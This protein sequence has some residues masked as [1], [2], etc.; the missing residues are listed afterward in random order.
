MLLYHYTSE[1]HL[2]MI[3]TAGFLKTTESNVSAT[4]EH[5]GPDV[6]W[7]TTA[8]EPSAG[9]GLAGSSVDKSAIRFSVE[10][11]KLAVY[12]WKTWAK[13]QG[14]NPGF[15]QSLARSGGAGT[16][17]ITTSAIP[18]S[19]W[20]EVRRMNPATVLLDRDALDAAATR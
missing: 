5:A 16:W 18:A 15:I 7:L 12:D 1:T 19:R 6:V 14:S 9:H 11:P 13:A 20:A 17:R 10:L 4:K 8:D 3:L 2:P